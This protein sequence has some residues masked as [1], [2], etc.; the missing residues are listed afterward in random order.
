MIY[1]FIILFKIVEVSISTVRIV[2]ITKGERKIGAFIAFF[3]VSLW[4]I[5]VST[6]LKLSPTH[7][8]FPL[9]I[10]WAVCLKSVLALACRR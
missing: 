3:E 9:G 2:L 5:L 4:V 7:L 8:A 6:V 10:S 1:L